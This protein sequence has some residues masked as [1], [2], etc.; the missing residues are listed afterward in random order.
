MTNS[1]VICFNIN[2]LLYTNFA[3]FLLANHCS[4]CFYLFIFHHGSGLA[5]AILQTAKGLLCV[6]H[7]IQEALCRGLFLG[8]MIKGFLS[9][10]KHSANNF[11]KKLILK[12]GNKKD[13]IRGGSHRPATHPLPQSRKSRQFSCA[14][15]L[16]LTCNLSAT[17]P[18]THFYLYSIFFPHILY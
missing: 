16:P 1:N 13:I 17:A 2:G 11:S 14:G 12:V 10:K 18:H 6:N 5:N 9:A 15:D 7:D 4:Q 3:F 8:H